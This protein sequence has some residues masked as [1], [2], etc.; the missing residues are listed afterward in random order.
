MKLLEIIV[1]PPEGLVPLFSGRWNPRAG[2][3]CALGDWLNI[4][5]DVQ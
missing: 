4:I 2:P 5:G 1:P 3:V